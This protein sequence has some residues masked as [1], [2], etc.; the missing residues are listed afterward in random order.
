MR[1]ERFLSQSAQRFPSKTALIAGQVRLSYADLD[2]QTTALAAALQQRGIGRNDRVLVFMDN[3]A[4]APL[5][6]FAVLKAGAT[7]SPINAST[8][9]DKLAYII[10]NCR[11]AAILTQ[12]K[13]AP[14]ADAAVAGRDVPVL[15]AGT[16]G[17]NAALAVTTPVAP[18]GGIDVD[19]A[20]LIYTSGS[21][22]RPKGVMMTHRNI[23]AASD[24]ITTYLENTSDDII[25]NVAPL[26]FDYGLYQLLMAVRMGATLVLEKSFAFPAAVFETMRREQ[27]TGFPLVPT[28]AA[29]ILQ[30]RDVE[31]LAVP[32]LRYITNTAAALPEEHIH[33]L[34]AM[35]PGASLYSMYGLT[36]CKRCTYLPPSQLDR[37]A[38]SVGIAIPNTEAYVADDAG[39]PVASGVIGE[40]VIRGPH[41]MQGYWENPTA[42]AERIRPGRNAWEKV[43]FTGDLFYAD[44]EGYL[45]FVGRKDDIIKTRGEKV[46]PKEVEAVLHAH[47]GVAEA[48]VVGVPDAI[49]GQAVKA[50]VVLS[51]PA[52]SEGELV[53]HCAKL[54]EDFMVPRSIEFRASLP[55]TDTGKVSR[56]LAAQSLEFT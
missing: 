33:R 35:F 25:L 23:D 27:V 31:A 10:D 37:R 12:K 54:L 3:A 47:P 6:I 30:M 42:T 16:S 26:A 15:I 19:L 51:D 4:E 17:W 36:E 56:R 53:R 52:V 45:Y 50:I 38:G 44:G 11:P 24:S 9:A 32:S 29:M 13:L 7:F 55:K 34:R 46:A 14:V 49:L 20:M 22:G 2:A 5:A 43:L 18:H 48:V 1:V 28:M 21:T 8:K 40:L 41:V 39:E